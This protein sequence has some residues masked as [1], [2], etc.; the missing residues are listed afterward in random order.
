MPSA[1]DICMAEL[2]EEMALLE[3]KV[4]EEAEKERI[5]KEVEEARLAKLEEE[6]RIAEE[7]RKRREEQEQRQAEEQ[8]QAAF[9]LAEYRKN[10]EK[11]EADKIE[12]VRTE[13]KKREDAD[14]ELRKATEKCRER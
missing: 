10:V 9:T 8:Q 1:H 5:A 11:A 4:A 6:K 3:R 2:H 7:E 13:F 12:A 14:V